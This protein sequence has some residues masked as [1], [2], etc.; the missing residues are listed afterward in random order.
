MLPLDTA[1]EDKLQLIIYFEYIFLKIW[2]NNSFTSWEYKYENSNGN[3][4]VTNLHI[5]FLLQKSLIGNN[6]TS[7]ISG[8]K[9]SY[10][11]L[12]LIL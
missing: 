5:D 7:L 12:P 3:L 10:T 2:N 11:L 4:E 6:D 9:I 1:N 8:Y